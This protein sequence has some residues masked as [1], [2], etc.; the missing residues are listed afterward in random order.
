MNLRRRISALQR[1]VGKPIAIRGALEPV[2]TAAHGPISAARPTCVATGGCIGQPETQNCLP[3]LSRDARSRQVRYECWINR[4]RKGNI[5]AY[6]YGTKDMRSVAPRIVRAENA[7]ACEVGYKSGHIAGIER[8]VDATG[9]VNRYQTKRG[10]TP[11][12]LRAHHEIAHNVTRSL[13]PLPTPFIEHFDGVLTFELLPA[14]RQQTIIA[15]KFVN[16]GTTVTIY[17]IP[18]LDFE[19]VEVVPE[20]EFIH[21]ESDLRSDGVETRYSITSSARS[22]ID[23]GTVRP[24]VLAVL[25]LMTSSIFV[26]RCTGMSPGFSPLR[27]RPT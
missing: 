9:A 14:N 23:C 8:H 2:L 13:V 17:I 10:R 12:I 3:F 24:S 11:L 22:R 7:V 16:R 21:V 25:R 20:L 15:V 1:F 5:R 18:V 19:L 6:E 4:Q 27:M 26:A